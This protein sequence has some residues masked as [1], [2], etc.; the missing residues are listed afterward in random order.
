MMPAWLAEAIPIARKKAERLAIRR[1]QRFI[2]MAILAKVRWLNSP[3]PSRQRT[4]LL[5]L[6]VEKSNFGKPHVFSA[7]CEVS[8]PSPDRRSV[9]WGETGSHS[10]ARPG[11]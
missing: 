4:H 6:A 1:R 3:T 10:H 2:L 11:Q 7:V 9:L 5:P 8:Q